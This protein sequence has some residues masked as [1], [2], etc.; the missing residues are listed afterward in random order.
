MRLIPI[1]FFAFLH[2][3]TS[4]QKNMKL[5][6]E[7]Q[8]YKQI[9]KNPETQFKDS[10]SLFNYLHELQL[11]AIKKGFLLTSIDEIKK[12]DSS[13]YRCK[14]HLGDK[15]ENAVFSMAPSDLQFTRKTAGINEKMLA[16]IALTP[17]E[18]ASTL[19]KIQS[20]FVNHG[21]AF[22][23]IKIDSAEF[24]GNQLHAKIVVDK[25]PI[26]VWQKIHIRGDST[27]SKK[28]ISNLI[29]I[30]EKDLFDQQKLENITKRIAQI[31]FIK[32]IKPSEILFTKEGAELYLYLKSIP[33]SSIN[34]IIGLQPNPVN[35]R[36]AI[37]GE[38]NLKLTNVLKR[39]EMLFVDW[40]AIQPQTQALR[41]QLTVPFLFKTA[42][43][44]EG[45]FNLYKRDSTFLEL[46]STAGV[47]YQLPQGSYVKVFYQN[48]SSNLLSG[49]QFSSATT[50]LASVKTNS[51]GLSFYRRQLDYIPNPSKGITLNMESAVGSRKAQKSDTSLVVKSTTFRGVILIEWF[52]P[53]AKRHVLKLKNAT[54][55]YYAPITYEN[56]VAR[57]GGLSSQRG[58][59][60]EEL[61][62]TAN[63][64]STIEYRFL[65]DKNSHAFA[66][67]DQTWYEKN[68]KKYASD[69]PYGFGAGFSFGTNLGIFSISY[70]LGKQLNNPIEFRN[71]KIHFGYVAYF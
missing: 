63:S 29:D 28:Y 50:N 65:V 64:T 66:F 54:Q 45:K 33:I 70:A 11:L 30:H 35:Q 13:T 42:F 61:F 55:L 32:E 4:G 41:S 49:A 8:N 17:S 47:N 39:G 27:L 7:N 34:G 60:E 3:S 38:V 2:F 71:G 5:I 59:N 37:T 46:I 51:Y 67:F 1:V 57:F 22:S 25:G 24:I 43:G 44:V 14:L 62:A 21:Y 10:T 58:F 18:I 68:A 36:L 6:F 69:W 53:L 48:N 31:N 52:I 26:V 23:S 16:R 19:K 56:E 40:R 9:K 20:V 15:F 12:I